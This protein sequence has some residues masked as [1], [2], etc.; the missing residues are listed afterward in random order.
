MY[1]EECLHK[2]TLRSPPSH[3]AKHFQNWKCCLAFE[4]NR[5]DYI[6]R[7]IRRPFRECDTRALCRK[8]CN[9][10]FQLLI[11]YC[12]RRCQ[13]IERSVDQ[14]KSTAKLYKRA[15][16]IQG[17]SNNARKLHQIKIR[18]ESKPHHALPIGLNRS[19]TGTYGRSSSPNT[20]AAL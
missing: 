14:I 15:R 8:R 18:K 5:R 19:F 11:A 4:Q 17:N 20:A 16:G 3:H 1:V 12:K 2:R 13:N 6:C 10:R 9:R 7:V